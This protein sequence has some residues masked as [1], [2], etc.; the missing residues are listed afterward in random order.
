VP[1][2]AGATAAAQDASVATGGDQPAEVNIDYLQAREQDLEAAIDK[3]NELIRGLHDSLK[4]FKRELAQVRA[5]LKR[6]AG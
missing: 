4:Q 5:Q 1:E 6:A 2:S 3:T